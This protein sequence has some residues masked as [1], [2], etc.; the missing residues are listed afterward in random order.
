MRTVAGP[1]VAGDPGNTH[2]GGGLSWKA[3]LNVRRCLRAQWTLHDQC[4]GSLLRE[5]SAAKR[6]PQTVFK[7]SVFRPIGLISSSGKP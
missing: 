3:M 6:L 1:G 4:F 2:G 5:Q 7:P